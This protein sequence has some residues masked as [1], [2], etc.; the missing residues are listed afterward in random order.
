MLLY[1]LF[2]TFLLEP[3]ALMQCLQQSKRYLN[4]AFILSGNVQRIHEIKI[5]LQFGLSVCNSLRTRY[6]H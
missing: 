4:V 5:R 6:W 3:K 1:F 2:Y